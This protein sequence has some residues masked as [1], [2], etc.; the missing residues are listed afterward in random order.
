MSYVIHLLSEAWQ[1]RG[2]EVE[3]TT[4]TDRA[5]GSDVLVF[6]HLDL[7]VTPPLYQ[8]FFER[9]ARVLNRGVKD[10]SKR[11]IS[12]NL[13][14]A[15]DE[16]DGPVIV[17]T[18]RNAGGEP[19][20]KRVRREGG[21]N[22]LLLNLA[23]RLPWT[24]TGMVSGPLDYKVYDTPRLVPR[25]VWHNPRLVVEKFIAERQGDLYCLRQYTF[26]GSAELNTIAFSPVPIV[27]ARNVV[28]REVLTETPPGL[29]E[30]RKQLGF[31]YGKFDYVMREGEVVLFDANRTPTA[32]AASKAGSASSLVLGLASGIDAYLEAA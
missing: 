13:L 30:L 26:L 31:D 9:C 21:I 3:V 27:K 25:A 15:A 6:P 1:Q 17:K 23:R 22:G 32:S 29:R 5:V 12:R 19:E 4:E 2:I 7:T 28:R 16:Y 14:S 20:F 24:V 10:I 11:R 18:N 8:S